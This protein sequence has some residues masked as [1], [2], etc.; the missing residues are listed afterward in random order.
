MVQRARHR[1]SWW[2]RGGYAGYIVN[3]DRRC[4]Y[5]M[6]YPRIACLAWGSLVWNPGELSEYVP[7]GWQAD[8]PRLPVEFA[9]VSRNGRLTL[10]IVEQS[11]LLQV[12]WAE[13]RIGTLA[14][15]VDALRLREGCA[16]SAVGVYPGSENR[17]GYR[18]IAEWAGAKGFE[19]VIWTALGPKF[20][21]GDSAPANA[22]AAVEYLRSL[23]ADVSGL[24]EEYVRRAPQQIRTP[25][26]EVIE[27]ELQWLPAE[28]RS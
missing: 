15:A 19:H 16:A 11:A 14:A 26:R 9:R 12:L 21:G 2:W 10:V 17:C 3:I 4:L 28:Q 6:K 25:F 13:M 5:A 23:P 24:A 18:G 8:G 20:S 22:H 1:S 27:R 7:G